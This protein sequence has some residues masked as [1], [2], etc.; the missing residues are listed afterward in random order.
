MHR[1]REAKELASQM[2]SMTSYGAE[3]EMRRNI[4]DPS[5]SFSIVATLMAAH[6]L[7]R[8]A[9]SAVESAV[10]TDPARRTKDV[11]LV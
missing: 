3:A 7:L 5:I 8:N 10:W 9:A 4:V 11:L 2:P 6:V 1:N